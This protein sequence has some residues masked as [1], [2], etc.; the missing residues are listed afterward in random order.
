MSNK[1]RILNF[2][3]ERDGDKY[4]DD[5]L[6]TILKIY[7]RQQ[8]NQICRTLFSANLIY[9]E[10]GLCSNCSKYKIVN[11]VV[12]ENREV[13]AEVPSQNKY[14]KKRMVSTIRLS[15]DE[16]ENRVKEYLEKTFKRKFSKKPLQVGLN[17]FHNFDLVSDDDA[18]VVECKSY[19]WTKSENFPSA[20]IST[21]IEALFYLSRIKASKKILVL[22]DDINSR[23]E[24]LVDVFVRRYDGIMD[25]VE[26][27][28]YT[29]GSTIQEDKVRIVRKSKNSWYRNLYNK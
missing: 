1:I 8:V 22:Q 21:A 20:K 10:K 5:C 2:L 14:T 23:G 15:P 6:S 12:V 24:S 18:I 25:D 19:S 26:V 13:K 4:C 3:K 9:R 27:W 29:A 7:P 11:W 17:K 16:F 28:A